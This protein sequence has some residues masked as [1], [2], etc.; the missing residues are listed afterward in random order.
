[1]IVQTAYTSDYGSLLV[2]LLNVA[3]VFVPKAVT[4]VM[5]ATMIKASMTAYSTAVGPS[6]DARNFFNRFMISSLSLF[7]DFCWT[8]EISQ[9]SG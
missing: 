1:M 7:D 8:S 5:Q 2:T 9:V 6:S 4:V 3:L